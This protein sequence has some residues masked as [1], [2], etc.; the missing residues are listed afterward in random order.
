MQWSDALGKSHEQYQGTPRIVS[1]VPSLTE[2]LVALDLAEALVG[3]TGFCIHP[4]QVVRR[5]AKL[6]GTK[7]FAI[8]KLRALRPTHVLVNI[9]ENRRE[10]VEALSGFV[11]HL[12]VTHPLTALDNLTLYR[13]LGGIFKRETQAAALCADFAREWSALCL[14]AKTLPRQRVLY[15]IWREPWL[16]VARDTYI[17]RMLASAGWDTLPIES[18]VRYPQ[19]DLPALAAEADIVFLASE[20]YPFREPHRRQLATLL[21]GTRSV[22]IDGEMVSWYGNRAIQ[23]LAYLRE[24]RASLADATFT[25]T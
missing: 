13:L 20:P 1:L 25:V 24:L 2:L 18:P 5:V 8:D 23:G 3:R 14:L 4:R 11:P 7:G 17:S 12:I 16:S 10:E 22:L 6:G 21:P 19:I 15:L 9:D